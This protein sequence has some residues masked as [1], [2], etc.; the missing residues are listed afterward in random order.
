LKLDLTF[1]DLSHAEPVPAKEF[2]LAQEFA[3]FQARDSWEGTTFHGFKSLDLRAKTIPASNTS[4]Y[5][6]FTKKI[7]EACAAPVKPK[8]EGKVTPAPAKPQPTESKRLVAP[9][10]QD[11]YKRGEDES[12]RK[13][14]ANAIE[15][16]GAA[17]KADPQYAEAWR[18]LGRAHM[19]ARHYSDAET[20]FRKYL[21]L[22]PN[23]H[24]AYLNMAWVLFNES[25]YEE[26]R[27]L[28]LKRIAAA[29][30][31]GDAL[32]RLGIAYLALHEP[33]QAVPVLER[34]VVQFPKY[35]EAHYAL[36]RA[37]LEN[38]QDVLAQVW[39]RKVL[40][41]DNSDDMLNSVAY[42]FAE[43]KAFLDLAEG[44]SQRS[45]DVVEK[46]LNNS[47]LATVQSNTW[48]T[49]I[50]LGHYWDT[51]GWIHFQQGK[52]EVAEKYLLA[53]WQVTDE[54]AIG[55]HLGRIY[56][57]QGHKD[58]AVEMYSAGLNRIPPNVPLNDDVKEWRKRL[59]DLLG[60]DSQVDG[61]LEQSRRK[62]SPLTM[63]SIAN[64]D[65]EQGVAQYTVM[66]D[67]NSKVIELSAT[68]DDPLV[69]LNSTVRA[70]TMPQTFPDTTLKKLPRLSTLAC[71]GGNQACTFTLLSA[72]RVAP[73][74]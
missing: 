70:I 71:M 36:G 34:S 16:F 25:K 74:N 64:P 3:E 2:H 32:F 58:Q 7:A 66:I 37:Y 5:V 11:L 33:A 44:W 53:A 28:M 56:E 21:A 24:L 10:A 48:T 49:V 26:D 42:L 27:D 35:V 8:I 29:P 40:E 4:E 39:F 43:H 68:S 31:D 72:S 50:K 57:I 23:D 20:A 41:L 69:N 30:D 65:G 17:T 12:K 60:G 47:T 22:A 14:W 73:L 55:F 1:T 54:P 6:A 13:N 52:I 38:H 61:R 15:A 67:A 59:A 18:E 45:I 63:V 46:E 51:M 9:E 62:K 19:Y